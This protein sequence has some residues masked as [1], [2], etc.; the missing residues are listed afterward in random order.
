MSGLKRRVS[1]GDASNS[2]NVGALE[3]DKDQ[4]KQLNNGSMSTRKRLATKAQNMFKSSG[5]SMP[6][7]ASFG[8]PSLCLDY[9]PHITATTIISKHTSASLSTLSLATM[10]RT[11]NFQGLPTPMFAA[12]AYYFAPN[13]NP[14]AKRTTKPKP[15][16]SVSSDTASTSKT[17]HDDIINSLYTASGP[18]SLAR[19]NSNATNHP[20]RTKKRP[21]TGVAST[22]VD[23]LV[24]VPTTPAITVKEPVDLPPQTT[25]TMPKPAYKL[26]NGKRHHPHPSSKAPYPRSYESTA[27]DQ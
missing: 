15:R 26:K 14:A 1:F 4:D 21:S 8:S 12:D 7:H 5:L 23:Q 22:N 6:A 27:I 9:S 17:S 20:R 10:P 25:P 3:V 18:A 2:A 24:P 19:T 11:D 13:T 16:S